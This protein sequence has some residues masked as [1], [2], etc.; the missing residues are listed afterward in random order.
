MFCITEQDEFLAKDSVFTLASVEKSYVNRDPRLAEYICKLISLDPA[1]R[2]MFIESSRGG[3]TFDKIHMQIQNAVSQQQTLL[4]NDPKAQTKSGYISPIYSTQFV[5]KG[6][7]SVW[8]NLTSDAMK[9]LLPDRV[10]MYEVI[11]NLWNDNSA[12]ARVQLLRVLRFVHLRYGA[13]KAIKT[14]FKEAEVRFDWEVYA[15]LDE[16]FASYS[17]WRWSSP[18]YICI[19]EEDQTV[20][21]ANAAIIREQEAN[22]EKLQAQLDALEEAD[23]SASSIEELQ[24]QINSLKENIQEAERN[25]YLEPDVESWDYLTTE[26]EA[27]EYGDYQFESGWTF[28][29]DPSQKT[30]AYLRRRARR[31]MR[32]FAKDFPEAFTSAAAELLLSRTSNTLMQFFIREQVE[33]WKR[34]QVSLMKV[35][36]QGRNETLVD[37]AYDFL[38]KHF[39]KEM[40]TVSSEWLYRVSQSKYDFI[41]TKALDYLQDVTGVEKGRF[42][43]E[44]YHKTIIGFLG[45]EKVQHSDTAVEFAV[46][47]LTMMGANP[48]NTWLVEAFPLHN[49]A[50]L[51][52]SENGKA[53]ELGNSLILGKDGVSPYESELKDQK[54]KRPG[55]DFFTVLLNDQRTSDFAAKQIRQRYTS[56]S[57]DWYV[58]QLTSDVWKTRNFATK[59]LKDSTMVASDADWANFSISLLTKVE[60]PGQI[61]AAA[62]DRLTKPDVTGQKIIQDRSRISLEFLR[63]LFVHPS[64]KVRGYACT[65]V[66]ERV[67]TPAD[68]GVGFLKSISTKREYRAQLQRKSPWNE[69]LGSFM[70][71]VLSEYLKEKIDDGVYGDTVGAQVRTWLSNEFT[72]EDIGLDWAFERVQWWATQYDFVRSILKRDV[73]LQELS[74][75]LPPLTKEAFVSENPVVNGARQMA[76]YVYNKCLDAGSKKAT[77]Y[78]TLLMERNPRYRKHKRLVDLEKTQVWPQETFDFAWFKRWTTSKREPIRQYA[79]ELSRYEMSYWVETGAVGFTDIREFF[80]GF[81]DVQSAIVRA[82]YKPLTP[83]NSSRIDLSSVGFKAA[84]LYPYCFTNNQREVDF[85]LQVILD[86]PSLFGKPDDLLMLSDSKNARVRQVVILVMWSLYKVPTTT[87]GWRPFPYS[88]VP[89]DPSRAIDPSRVVGVDPNTL[90]GEHA[91]FGKSKWFLGKGNP[92]ASSINDTRLTEDAQFDLHEFL[93]RILYALPRSPEGRTAEDAAREAKQAQQFGTTAKKKTPLNSSWKNKRTLVAA[94]RDLAVRVPSSTERNQMTSDE[95]QSFQVEQKEFARFVLP[96]LEEFTSVRSKMLHNACLT[97]VVQIKSTHQ[98]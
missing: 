54:D 19:T 95:L 36:E 90:T 30:L 91:N 25:Q 21:E 32:T 27:D 60:D 1:P 69:S 35:V 10:G 87:P 85:A 88:V 94:I 71:P 7:Q 50:R 83:V 49:V 18:Q 59:M 26:I 73:T 81:F 44:G 28:K 67:C 97:A 5:W 65:L 89:Y 3:S 24:L 15:I 62:W 77:F 39:R 41:H 6:H 13:W 76:W 78:K 51:M 43:D 33:L 96:V 57:P 17:G 68:L 12:Y 4:R 80:S 98:L 2:T 11:L 70:S 31:T 14:I 63:F 52:R 72:L 61:F 82:I 53:R 38:K 93:R 55:L 16:R 84:E 75:L 8:D 40:K 42:Y 64:K 86:Y 37:W 74:T 58:A 20:K 34:D 66:D 23:G 56:L 79:I 9:A 45:F 46:E 22:Q 48:E 29:P 47:Y 92:E